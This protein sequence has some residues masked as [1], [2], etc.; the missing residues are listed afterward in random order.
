M[1]ALV[2]EVIANV[3]IVNTQNQKKKSLWILIPTLVLLYIS[4]AGLDMLISF[5]DRITG[6][7]K[8]DTFKEDLAMSES[9]NKYDVV[10]D[11]GY[12]GKYQFGDARLEDFKNANKDYKFTKKEFLNDPSLQEDV[13]S[14]HVED[15]NNY[16]D[17]RGLDKYIGTEINGVTITRDGLIAGAHLGG[18]T[19]LKNFLSTGKDKEDSYGTSI[20]EY[21]TKFSS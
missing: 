11:K 18:K 20:S 17:S 10:N 12:M 15:I 3:R 7:G 19:G 13:F 9:S 21:I 14:W 1:V 2:V 6:G 4:M 8:N 5:V 16:I